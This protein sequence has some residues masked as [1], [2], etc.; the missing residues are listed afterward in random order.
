MLIPAFHLL[1]LSVRMEWIFLPL[2]IFS[3][4]VA[5]ENDKIIL[6]HSVKV[7]IDYPEMPQD[8]SQEPQDKKN[9]TYPHRRGEERPEKAE[10]LPALF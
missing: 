2:R 1:V 5:I 6:H 10:R 7:E 4:K 3:S 8:K 9:D